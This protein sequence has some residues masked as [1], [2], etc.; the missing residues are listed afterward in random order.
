MISVNKDFSTPPDG[1]LAE[2]CL[3]KIRVSLIEKNEHS[4]SNNYYRGKSIESLRLIYNNKCA[5]C[6][7]IE[8]PGSTLRVDHFR[9]KD[10][11]Q[12]TNPV[13]DGYYWLGY[14][15]SNLILTCEKCNRRKSNK[16]PLEDEN[17]RVVCKPVLNVTGLPNQLSS[18]ADLNYL[19]SE[20]PLLLNP[21]IDEVEKHLVF[22]ADGTVKPLTLK[23]KTSIN[24]Y[25][26]YREPLNIERKKIVDKPLIEIKRVLAD[27]LEGNIDEKHF[28]YSL[29]IIYSKMVSRAEP[30]KQYSRMA[31][32][33]Y[34][35]FDVFIVRQ[36]QFEGQR[37]IIS[38]TFE[39][40]RN[41]T[42]WPY[43]PDIL[44]HTL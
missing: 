23:G 24:L 34:M 21:E 36:L 35:K 5:Y 7:T 27:F 2:N 43:A 18:R 42:L 39:K 32:W 10:K 26:L 9:P 8:S 29:N 4:F 15:W 33:T 38:N 41:N 13:Y 44:P 25:H 1:L 16:F 30:T 6:E 17:C 14:E 3:Q 12:D 19:K 37:Q 22:K 40:F 11:V 31:F 28:H 20:R